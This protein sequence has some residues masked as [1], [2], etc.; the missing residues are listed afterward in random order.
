MKNL[1][2]LLDD[3]TSGD[4]ESAEN[5]ALALRELGEQAIKPLS[6][7]LESEEADSRWWAIRTL[8]LFNSQ[9]TTEYLLKGLNDPDI[10]VLKC[11]ALGL[12]ENPTP[13]AIPELMA[14]LGH[15]DQILSRLA[16]DALISI[17]K[18]AT[19]GL[20]EIVENG[21]QTA[22]MEA[23]RALSLIGDQDSIPAL[24]KVLEDGSMMMRY[25]A[26]KGLEKM[27]DGMVFFK[28]E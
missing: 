16:G 26:E 18:E 21:E 22:K 20:V 13:T 7:L 17:G 23:V 9:K 4:D 2:T 3:L 5:A 11:A 15:E 8:A 24:F 19:Q 28:P 6:E 1:D 25:W 12:R 14:H 27:G 10:E